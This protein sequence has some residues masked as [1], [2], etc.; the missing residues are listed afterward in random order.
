MKFPMKI[1]MVFLEITRTSP[2][3]GASPALRG[4]ALNGPVGADSVDSQ[5]L[6]AHGAQLMDGH[7]DGEH[8]M[9]CFYFF[10]CEHM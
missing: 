10:K 8:P 7:L 6:A 2:S 1:P 3:H 5:A 9:V 4:Q